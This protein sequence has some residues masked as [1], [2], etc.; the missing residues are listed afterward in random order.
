MTENKEE[1]LVKENAVT[2]ES[3]ES[4]PEQYVAKQPTD[5]YSKD[6]NGVLYRVEP[7]PNTDDVQ[8]Q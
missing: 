6:E 1:T 8:K 3:N 5:E 4:V 2:S 7:N